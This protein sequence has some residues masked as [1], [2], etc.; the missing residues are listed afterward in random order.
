MIKNQIFAFSLLALFFI[1]PYLKAIQAEDENNVKIV[2]IQVQSDTIRAGE[3][4]TISATL[5]NNS[6]DTI[7]VKNDCSG[8]FSVVFDS[9]ARAEVKKVCNWM[10]SQIILKPGENFT[11]TGLSNLVYRAITP[12]TANATITFSYISGNKTAPNFSFDNVTNI[13][14][15]FLYIVSNQSNQTTPTILP[16]LAQFKSGIAAKDIQCQQGLQLI[17]KAKDGNPACV[18]PDTAVKLLDRGWAKIS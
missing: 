14:K 13:S 12:G 15:S 7:T 2:N 18:R 11:G 9:H 17:I 3:I 1:S 8:P 5:V 4:F 10:A 6:P 16:P